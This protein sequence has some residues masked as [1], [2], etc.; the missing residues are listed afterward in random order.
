M[1]SNN[2][3][4]LRARAGVV[5]LLWMQ[6]PPDVLRLPDLLRSP[7]LANN[8]TQRTQTNYIVPISI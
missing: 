8:V 7:S 3:D 2:N 4:A 1:I 5:S 6:I